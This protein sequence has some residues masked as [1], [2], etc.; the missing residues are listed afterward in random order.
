[1]NRWIVIS[2]I[3]VILLCCLCAAMGVGA[4]LVYTILDTQNTP[5]ANENPALPATVTPVVIRPTLSPAPTRSSPGQ[6]PSATG[7]PELNP[8]GS[9]PASLVPT[10]TLQ[11]LESMVVP[12]ADLID[13]AQRLE[14]KTNIPVTASAPPPE[15]EIGAQEN[16]W[17]TNQDNNQSSQVK[18]VLRAKS[19]HVYFWIEEGVTY[20]DSDLQKL[21]DTFE[22]KIYPTNRDFFG[23]EWTPGVDNDPH[24]YILFAHNLGGSVAGYYSSADEYSNQAHKYSNMHEMFIMSADHIDL[25]DES[26]YG[27]LAH[28]FQ[29]MIHWYRDR[30]EETWM[31]EGF[32]ELA[33]LLNNYD[34]GG[35]DYSFINNPDL[36][37]TDWP[38]DPGGRGE[39]YG[40]AFLFMTYFLDRFG[41]QATQALVTDPENGMVGIDTILATLG[42]TDPQSGQKIGA[43]DVFA[44]WV[45]TNYLKDK[46][47]ADGRYTYHNYPDAPRASETETI[48][49]CPSETITRDV[50]QYGADYINIRCQG[51]YTLHFEGSIQVPVLQTQYHSGEFA[52]WSNKGDQSDMTLTRTFDFSGVS[53]PLTL[54]F[55]TWYDLEKDYDYLYLTASTDGGNTWQILKTPSGT[56]EDPSGNSYGWAYNGLSGGGE[57]PQWIQESVDLSQFAGKNVLLR[58]EYVTDA[59]VNGEGLLLD[60]ITIPEINYAT[61]FESD[62]GGWEANGFVR[63]QNVLPQTF[64]LTLISKGQQTVVEKFVLSNENAIDIP[65]QLTGDVDEVTLAVSGTTRFT[66]QK[67]PY[68]ITIRP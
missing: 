43:D 22:N 26:A 6:T 67:A 56:S 50:S 62:T 13:L 68:Q 25:G 61:D 49:T 63:I 54:N 45:A 58:F 20:N 12:V 31:N 32:S 51:N 17:V 10:D 37:L 46:K 38:T 3:A 5:Q 35:F 64:R 60:D 41:D 42:V 15:L 4:Y 65:L 36:Q 16:Y 47:V 33:M 23:S 21:V 7:V 14:G 59:A 52:L 29:H 34:T 18:A 2:L 30:N 19:P 44:D 28:E 48:D 57:A 11:S 53:G 55:W 39:H 1:M 24:L 9:E 8:G 27:V 66:R 40:A